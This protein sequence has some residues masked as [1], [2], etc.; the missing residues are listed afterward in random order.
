MSDRVAVIDKGRIIA[1]AA[2]EELKDS[3]KK[4]EVTE[5]EAQN[6]NEQ[7][8]EKLRGIPTVTEVVSSIEDASSLKGVIK[9]HSSHGRNV[10]PETLGILV[11]D[12]VE[13]SN[14]K[15][16]TPTLEDVF[17]QRT[18]H[19]FWEAGPGA[20]VGRMGDGEVGSKS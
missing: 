14:V 12:G 8:V 7:T 1:M 4:S 13:V 6:I 18:G 9:I 20:E 10:I 16:A 11:K 19:R 15:I 3:V 2:P 5:V 17:V